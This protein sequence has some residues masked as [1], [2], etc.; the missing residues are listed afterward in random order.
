MAIIPVT[1]EIAPQELQGVA[2]GWGELCLGGETDTGIP[3]VYVPLYT[4]CSSGVCLC[5]V[6]VHFLLALPIPL[7]VWSIALVLWQHLE[8]YIII[9]PETEEE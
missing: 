4:L 7:G 1:S 2:G 9:S 6:C 8:Y 5:I 3:Q